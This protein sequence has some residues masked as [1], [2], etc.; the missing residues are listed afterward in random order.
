VWVHVLMC[1]EFGGVECMCLTP[2][3]Q[4]GEGGRGQDGV[5]RYRTGESFDADADADALV[6]A[7]VAARTGRFLGSLCACLSV[8]LFV[9]C[10]CCG[11]RCS[12]AAV[13]RF[14]SS[15]DFCSLPSDPHWRVRARVGRLCV[16]QL[17]SRAIANA[18]SAATPNFHPSQ[19]K[20]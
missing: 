13:V 5:A 9:Y 17:T 20:S 4:R 8:C 6:A 15:A 18:C 12:V 2:W 11:S 7:L 3:E 19:L 14:F 10:G 16:L 1:R